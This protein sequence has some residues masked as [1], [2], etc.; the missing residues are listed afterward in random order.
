MSIEQLNELPDSDAQALVSQWCASDKW[1]SKV[2]AGRPYQNKDHLIEMASRYWQQM[3]ESDLL[4]AYAA[5]PLI[6]DVDLLRQKYANT[7]RAEQGQVMQADEGVLAELARLNLAYRDR[8]GF[9]FIVFAS[10]KSAAEMLALLQER[11][12]N[13]REVELANAA[14]E[15]E[16][17]MQLRLNQ[18][19][20]GSQT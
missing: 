15:Q 6:G 13:S 17:I 16:K 12:T 11:I 19:L 3:Q 18:Y 10:G 7:A 1:V 9:I 20:A 14:N 8:F 4:Q 5:H 2:V